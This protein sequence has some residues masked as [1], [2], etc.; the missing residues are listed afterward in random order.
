MPCRQATGVF[1][2]LIHQIFGWTL[3][4]ESRFNI[5]PS[6][7]RKDSYQICFLVSAFIDYKCPQMSRPWKMVTDYQFLMLTSTTFLPKY[8][9]KRAGR[10]NHHTDDLNHSVYKDP[11]KQTSVREQAAWN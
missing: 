11:E 7:F 1:D 8:Q 4:F 2:P 6:L 3:P 9:E 5:R 10:K